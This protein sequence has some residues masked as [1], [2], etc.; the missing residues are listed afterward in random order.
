[1]GR[2]GLACM[3]RESSDR[4]VIHSVSGTAV[5]PEEARLLWP[6]RQR[7]VRRNGFGGWSDMRVDTLL[8]DG[9]LTLLDLAA[10]SSV[11][12]ASESSCYEL[13]NQAPL[14]PID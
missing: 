12:R 3:N 8:Q 4:L 2:R 9:V 14:V 11:I 1:M 13:V 10:F 7:Y 5:M 6:Y